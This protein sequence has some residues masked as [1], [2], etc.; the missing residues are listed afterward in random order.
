[1]TT[2]FKQLPAVDL[3]PINSWTVDDNVTPAISHLASQLRTVFETT[4][5]AY[6]VNHGVQHDHQAIN[7]M[8]RNFF[9]ML[10]EKKMSVAV[11]S[12]NPNN[13]NTYRG[14]FPTHDNADSFKEGFEIGPFEA[15]DGKARTP[16]P[17][18]NLLEVNVWPLDS[19]D[20]QKQLKSYYTQCRKL[21]E[22][23]MAL[24]AIGFQLDK[25]YF[26]QHFNDTISTLRI[27]HYPQR[28]TSDASML[29]CSSHTDSGILT[30]LYQDPTGGLEVQNSCDG[31]VPVPYVPESFVI[32]LGDLMSRWTR[33]RFVA[34]RHRVLRVSQSRISVPF[35][36]EPNVDA[37][38]EPLNVV[39]DGDG[40][41]WPSVVYG[42]YL[43]RKMTTE[44]VEYQ[45]V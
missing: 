15:N 25:N 28:A 33:G 20:L 6:I 35:F 40:D 45:N 17:K 43:I 37:L 39:S 1:M 19:D 5:F 27:L 13:K 24:V 9:Q 36:F 22:K 41:T 8:A 30:I 34:T 12:A 10:L 38:I 2:D 23:I 21:G 29:S 18:I 42:D 26:Q 44:F 11:K 16:T 7:S 14:Y 32:N 31:W 4:G 3:S